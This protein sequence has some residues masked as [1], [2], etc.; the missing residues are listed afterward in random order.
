MNLIVRIVVTGIALWVATVL[1]P[2]VEVGGEGTDQAITLGLVAVVFG[3]VNA[4]IAPILKTLA[5]PLYVLT[6]GLFALIVNAVLF[7]LVGWI[8][9]Q[10]ALDFIV[11]DFLSALLGAVVVG[12][13]SWA[14]GL[15]ARD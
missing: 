15:L 2:G 6:F 12:L 7:Q 1:V 13:V 11:E 14:V 10:L 3:V 8:A 5:L 9:S 4:I